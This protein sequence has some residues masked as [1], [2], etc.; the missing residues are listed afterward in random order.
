MYMLHEGAA[1][2]KTHNLVFRRVL[3]PRGHA[4]NLRF[5]VSESA[6]FKSRLVFAKNYA[7]DPDSRIFIFSLRGVKYVP[8][9]HLLHFAFAFPAMSRR[10]MSERKS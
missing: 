4:C 1:N 7:A 5:R 2:T 3:C 9:L 8:V 6:R 10:S